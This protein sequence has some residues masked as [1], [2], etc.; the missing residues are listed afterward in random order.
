MNWIHV[1]DNYMSY[2]KK[3]N[4]RIPNTNYS[5]RYKPLFGVLF[6]NDDCNFVA[7]IS[8]Y[9]EKHLNYHDRRD[10]IKIFDGDK[11]IAVI[12]LNSMFPVPKEEII[13]VTYKNINQ[14]RTFDSK[15]SESKYINF[16][17]KEMAVI[18]RKD[19]SKMA[20]ELYNTV[21]NYPSSVIA[22]R[23]ADFK[24]LECR[25]SEYILD[26]YYGLK[27]EISFKK[28]E[29]FITYDDIEIERTDLDIDEIISDIE[30]LEYE[31]CITMKM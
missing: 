10:F 8:S 29:F 20:L 24:K 4:D 17:Q 15:V 27:T 28:N 14:F 22:S 31:N 1:N 26:N 6:A 16:L 9:K 3:I 30:T 25:C 12:N 21:S 7:S 2:I 13:N 11:P 19:I 18:N 5:E 23:C